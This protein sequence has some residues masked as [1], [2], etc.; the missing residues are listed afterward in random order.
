MTILSG[1][2]CAERKTNDGPVN[3][4]AVRLRGQL[5]A[6]TSREQQ[7]ASSRLP[8]KTKYRLRGMPI[9]VVTTNP[10]SV[11]STGKGWRWFRP[12]LP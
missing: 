1:H 11:R 12:G 4:G 8:V 2:W 9:T 7:S 5:A 3:I 6:Y 10:S